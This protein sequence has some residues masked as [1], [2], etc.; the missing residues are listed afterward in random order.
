M[1]RNEIKTMSA[2]SFRP[3]K[4]GWTY[5]KGR[6]ED[7]TTMTSSLPDVRERITLSEFLLVPQKA[8]LY[9]FHGRDSPVNNLT[10]CL[11][12]REVVIPEKDWKNNSTL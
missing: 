6:E 7:E 12:L 1:G 3:T 2:A 9:T 11:T 8:S 10:F 5:K 4:S